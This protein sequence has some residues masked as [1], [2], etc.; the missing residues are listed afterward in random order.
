MAKE[1]NLELAIYQSHTPTMMAIPVGN[2]NLKPRF[3]SNGTIPPRF[4]SISQKNPFSRFKEENPYLWSFEQLCSTHSYSDLSPDEFRVRL[5]P[6]SL[7][8]KA[9][10]WYFQQDKEVTTNWRN[11]RDKFCAKNSPLSH[12]MNSQF[13]TE[14][15]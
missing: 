15:D 5:F 7:V 12:L 4:L 8:G 11:L 10:A 6:F 13:P 2:G 3:F 14:E 9:R 1:A